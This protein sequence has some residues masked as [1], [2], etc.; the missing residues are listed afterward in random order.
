MRDEI[1]AVVG[2]LEVHDKLVQFVVDIFLLEKLV[3]VRLESTNGRKLATHVELD[4]VQR[5]EGGAS[6]QIPFQVKGS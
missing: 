2:C 5:R 4:A 3:V 6:L 1:W